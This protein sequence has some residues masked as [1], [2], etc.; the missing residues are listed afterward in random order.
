[1]IQVNA[2]LRTQEGKDIYDLVQKRLVE[3]LDSFETRTIPRI[4]TL[5]DP[6]FKKDGFLR[7]SNA[8]QAAK[9]LELELLSL[10]STTPRRPPTPESTSN[11]ASSK[12]SFL[13]NKPK[14]KSTRADAIIAT[15]QYME[16][17]NIPDTCDPLKYWEMTADNELKLVAKKFF[18][19]Q[20]SS[21]ESERVFSKAGQTISDRRTRLKHEVVDQLLFLNRNRHFK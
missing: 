20:A 21:C 19:I 14:V 13:Q 2:Q 6:R 4:A 7:S 15:R 8:D 12:F 1:M 11:E 18:C 16:K 9:A 10:K 3:R 17:E 5:V